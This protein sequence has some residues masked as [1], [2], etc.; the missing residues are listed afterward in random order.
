[1][2]EEVASSDIDNDE[3]RAFVGSTL[4]AIALGISDAQQTTNQTKDSGFSGYN[5]PKTVTFDV[6]VSAKRTGDAKAGFKVEV[7]SIGAN[8]GGARSTE[9]Q[10]TSRISFEV[11]WGFYQTRP[12]DLA[13]LGKNLA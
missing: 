4:R 1:M 5:M 2:S 11:P 7:F 12:I 6:A 10:S 13:A 9:S 3:L 8:A